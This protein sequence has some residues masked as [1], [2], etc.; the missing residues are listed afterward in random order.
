VYLSS[1]LALVNRKNSC[2][3]YQKQLLGIPDWRKSSPVWALCP[4]CPVPEICPRMSG[5]REMSG[6]GEMS[7]MRGMSGLGDGVFGRSPEPNGA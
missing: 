6:L 4:F 2:G 5:L 3:S 1:G 7:P